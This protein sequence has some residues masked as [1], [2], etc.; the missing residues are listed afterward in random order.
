MAHLL[1][2]A[3]EHPDV[4][5]DDVFL[6]PH[7]DIVGKV[8]ERCTPDEAAELKMLQQHADKEPSPASFEAL[9]KFKLRLF[10]LA[11]AYGVGK[12]FSRDDIDMSPRGGLS[13]TP[14][15]VA[16]MNAVAGKRMA[17]AIARVGGIAA[18]PQDKSEDEIRGIVTYLRTRHATYDT[19]VTVNPDTKIRDLSHFIEKRAHEMAIVEGEDHEFLGVIGSADVKGKDPD[20]TIKETD[21]YRRKEDV[22]TGNDGIS[23]REAF[24][25]MSLVPYLPILGDDKRVVGVL[26]KMD[27]A[28][29]LRY[30]PNLDERYGGLRA[31]FTVGALNK[32]PLERVKLLI[33][34]GI[35]DI[36]L[37]TANFDQGIVP[38][39]N[40]EKIADI[41]DQRNVQIN[42]MAGNVV[43]REA[44]RSIL[45]AGAKF[46]KVGVGP[47]AMCTTRMQ[48][49]VGRPQVAA[50]LETAE[51][52]QKLGGYVVA[53]GGIQHPRDVAIALAAG[54][55]YVMMGSM[56]ASTY[57]SPGEF[58]TDSKGRY[59]VNFGMASRAASVARTSRNGD[60]TD[61][62]VFR[63]Y[64]G[65][66]A[67]GIDES[68]VYVKPGMESVALMH[69]NFI[70]GPASSVAYANAMSIPEFRR[71]AV[72]GIQTRSGFAEGT[73]KPTL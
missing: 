23:P 28:M 37:D 59:K 24:D 44:V 13:K 58:R 72:M 20:K 22:I 65:H 61:R 26:S 19:P 30:R 25:A 31:I 70:D 54:A 69:H 32:N 18:V 48:T 3:A 38:F 41:A 12:A 1:F 34:L 51:E 66:R 29:R 9:K 57:E 4:T 33:D 17:E 50:I 43:T 35:R 52:A 11:E 42:L 14:I 39:R 53:D 62:E 15:I 63:D 46:V 64:V 2:K 21:S 16:N 10:D 49:G 71:N 6:L 47:G 27:A 68:R 7:N 55:D 73:A 40:A 56:F 45:T 67:E 5:F 8:Q 36:L 60:R